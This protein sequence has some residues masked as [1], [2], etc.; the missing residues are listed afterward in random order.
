M[1]I[2]EKELSYK[3][4]FVNLH[5]KTK[6]ILEVVFP[7]SVRIG[8]N[9]PDDTTTSLTIWGNTNITGSINIK[10]STHQSG[11]FIC[12]GS[13]DLSNELLCNSAIIT[14]A[15][16]TDLNVSDDVIIEDDLN[17]S[18]SFRTGGQ[19]IYLPFS[20]DSASTSRFYLSF[21][22]DTESATISDIQCAFLT[23]NNGRIKGVYLQVNGTLGTTTVS[24]HKNEDTTI[25]TSDAHSF[26]GQGVNFFDLSSVTVDGA[27]STGNRLHIGFESQFAP[28]DVGG[29]I[30]LE[31]NNLG[32][33]S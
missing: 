14:N 7:N 16:I 26:S 4:F 21:T 17:V 32:E 18:G 1:S 33:Y 15:T 12:S 30:I 8:Y 13:I 3:E 11:S 24:F 31:M 10:G 28:N 23:P 6:K 20:F 27:F 9:D 5:K 22:N 2:F 29:V 25:L 19:I